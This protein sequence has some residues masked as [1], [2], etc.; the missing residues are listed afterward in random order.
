MAKFSFGMPVV[1]VSFAL[2]AAQAPAYAQSEVPLSNGNVWDWRDHQPT[3][4][5][6]SRKE[7]EAGVAP[8]PAQIR[9]NS[10]TV[11]ELY[12]QLMH[13]PPE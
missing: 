3:E 4:A 9:S 5:G 2:L 8:A 11:D 6:V 7:K 1:A 13:Q 12:Q 10:A